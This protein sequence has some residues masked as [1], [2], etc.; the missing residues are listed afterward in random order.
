MSFTHRADDARTSGGARRLRELAL[1]V[2][3]VIGVLCI[4]LAL[5]SALFG[6]TPLVFRSGSMSPDI[7]TGSLAL[8]RSVPAQELEVGDVVSVVNEQG[9][10]VTHRAVDLAPVPG[11]S[12]VVATLKGDAN[13]VPDVSPYVIEEADRVMV[14]APGLGYAVSWITS[15]V[16]IF[17]GGMLA[18][19]LMMVAFGRG[20]P[21]TRN[22]EMSAAVRSHGELQEAHN[23]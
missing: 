5:A 7:P 14:H 22:A 1:N 23:V 8:A 2:G 19:A 4:V 12:A 17:L 9:V 18:G 15:P 10:R 21:R 3:A 16:A 13:S 6:V 20:K 11:G